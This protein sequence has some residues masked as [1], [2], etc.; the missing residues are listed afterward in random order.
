MVDL[1][2]DK[3]TVHL[4]TGP[5]GRTYFGSACRP[6]FR[7][8]TPQSLGHRQSGMVTLSEDKST[9]KAALNVNCTA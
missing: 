9:N 4:R 3:V 1:S 8:S 6:L 2:S 5:R 7:L